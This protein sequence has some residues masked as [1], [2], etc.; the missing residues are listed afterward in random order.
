LLA[1]PTSS[2][3]K[4]ALEALAVLLRAPGIDSYATVAVTVA[5][6]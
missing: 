2:K 6:C 5:Q 1:H 4:P 3:D